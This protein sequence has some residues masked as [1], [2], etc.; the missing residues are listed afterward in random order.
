MRFE[1]E[2]RGCKQ[3]LVS[4]SWFSVGDGRSRLC[5]HWEEE[6]REVGEGERQRQVRD[7]HPLSDPAG[8]R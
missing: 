5:D 4:F 2:V 1:V 7:E 8:V 3:A 6:G